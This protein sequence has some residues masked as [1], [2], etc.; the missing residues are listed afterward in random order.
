MWFLVVGGSAAAVHYL[1]ALVL[2]WHWGHA[3][4]QA[5]PTHGEGARQA[6][7]ANLAAFAVA[8]WVS[9][10]GHYWL[11]FQSRQAHAQAL[12]RFLGVAIA[13][14]LA[15][16]LL[17]AVLLGLAQWPP[18]LALGCTLVLVAAGTFLLS[19]RLA[20]KPGLPAK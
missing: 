16:Q 17:Y 3:P 11:S 12:P 5:L 4:W 8:F 10:A 18:F 14:F 2:L 1:V 20:F 19:R 9:Y 6:M 15:N 7:W 13:G